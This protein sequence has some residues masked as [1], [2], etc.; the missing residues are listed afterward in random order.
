MRVV[1]L[2]V[3]R[4]DLLLLLDGGIVENA[5]VAV[6]LEGESL[7]LEL[8]GL[9]HGLMLTQC[10]LL[11]MLRYE[12]LLVKTVVAVRRKDVWVFDEIVVVEWLA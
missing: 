11:R 8:V 7:L 4:Y 3:K 5:G 6:E 2:E 9:A 1:I 12:R 10:L